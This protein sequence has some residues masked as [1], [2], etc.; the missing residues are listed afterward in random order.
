M[1]LCDCVVQ[2]MGPVR[3]PS[4]GGRSGGGCWDLQYYDT[5]PGAKLGLYGCHENVPKG[6]PPLADWESFRLNANGTITTPAGLCVTAP[7]SSPAPSADSGIV[8]LD[9]HLASFLLM[10]GPY[11]WIGFAWVVSKQLSG[12]LLLCVALSLMCRPRAGLQPAVRAPQGAGHRLR[13]ARRRLQGDLA[14]RVR[15]RVDEGQ[16]QDGLQRV[17]GHGGA[18]VS[19]RNV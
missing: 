17:G 2:G 5:Q 1:T 13:D 18:E 8:D 9:E 10:R 16:R 4:F 14:R 6:E 11:A 7:S 12:T 3:A 19:C 15:A